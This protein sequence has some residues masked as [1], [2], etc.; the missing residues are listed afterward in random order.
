MT[1]KYALALWAGLLLIAGFAVGM[2]AVRLDVGVAQAQADMPLL[3]QTWSL[4]SRYFYGDMPSDQDLV[5]GALDGALESLGDPRTRLVRPSSASLDQDTL[6][7]AFGGIGVTLEWVDEEIVLQPQAGGPAEKAGVLSGDVLLGIDGELVNAEAEL[8]ALV[9]QLRG[10]VGSTVALVIRRGTPP[11]IVEVMVA[12][13]EVTEPTVSYRIIAD[14]EPVV[15]YVAISLFGER[16]E[17]ELTA[18]LKTLEADGAQALVLDLSNDPGGIVD[19]AVGVA[20]RFTRRNP[21][22]VEVTRDG[23]RTELRAVSRL[24]VTWPVAI[25]VNEMTASAAEI[26]AGALQ[27]YGRAELV[28]QVTRG[29]GSVQRVHALS[30]GSSLHVTAARWLTPSGDVIEGTGLTPDWEVDG[31]HEAAIAQAVALLTGGEVSQ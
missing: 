19:V 9:A 1:R 30:D 4:V 21:I 15:G 16:T 17:E 5:Y 6:R 29:K 18:A 25:V 22:A 14:T 11:D 20:S 8:D 26:V 24:Q 7:G 13:A 2:V 10:E 28:G 27:D 3:R 12:R 31:D 23:Q